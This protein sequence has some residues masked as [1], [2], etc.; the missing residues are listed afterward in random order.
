VLSRELR[1]GVRGSGE[2]RKQRKRERK[3]RVSK[4]RRCSFNE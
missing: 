4:Q 2:Q 3:K 1:D